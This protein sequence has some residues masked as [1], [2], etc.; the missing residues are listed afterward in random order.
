[1]NV[2]ENPNTAFRT[3]GGRSVVSLTCSLPRAL[4]LVCSHYQWGVFGRAPS[5][6]SFGGF[7][8][9]FHI[10]CAVLQ[11]YLLQSKLPAHHLNKD[12]K[13]NDN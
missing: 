7:L 12:N 13:N 3:T 4:I 6:L 1:M 10:S 8:C 2:S 5:E 11:G 9:A